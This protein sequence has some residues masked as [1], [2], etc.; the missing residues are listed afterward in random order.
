MPFSMLTSLAGFATSVKDGTDISF[1][2]TTGTTG[3]VYTGTDILAQ[4]QMMCRQ[5]Q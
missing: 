1:T 4:Q 2:I 5:M 3:I